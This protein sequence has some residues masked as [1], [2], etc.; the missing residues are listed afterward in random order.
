MRQAFILLLG[1]ALLVLAGCGSRPGDDLLRA[2]EAGDA[3]TVTALLGQG[4]RADSADRRGYGAL[5]FAAYRGH[6]AIVHQLLIHGANVNAAGDTGYT[7]LH[8]AAEGGHP[9]IVELLLEHGADPRA[10]SRH[11]RTPADEARDPAL[12]ERLRAAAGE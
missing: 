12:R 5:Y 11:D 7:P 6:E 1:L 8:A 2:V 3:A 10:K 4:V 9:A